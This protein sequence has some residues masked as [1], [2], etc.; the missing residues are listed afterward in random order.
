M[1]RPLAAEAAD[2]ENREFQMEEMSM[3]RG[4]I[5]I[6]VMLFVSTA[7]LS[8][9]TRA[10]VINEAAT[11]ECVAYAD[12]NIRDRDSAY[13][14]LL[15]R[16]ILEAV[17]ED[18]H[19]V[20]G[21]DCGSAIVLPP[22]VSGVAA[23]KAIASGSRDKSE[24]CAVMAGSDAGAD[25]ILAD[26]QS[27]VRYG[28]E[29]GVTALSIG[30]TNCNVGTE[31]VDCQYRTNKHPVEGLGLY[32]LNGD[33]FE[34]IG[35]S[36]V[37]H[38]FYALSESFCGPC[39]DVTNG[40]QLGVGCSDSNSAS[41]HACQTNLSPRSTINA[42]TG[43]F[44]HPW[45][46]WDDPPP[47]SIIERRLQVRTDDL[48]PVRNAG[49]RYFIEAHLI[50]PDDAA[51][52]TADNNASY[53]E[54][55]LVEEPPGIYNLAV[56]GDW[57]TQREQPAV[58]AWQDCDSSV[59]ETDIRVP[60]EGLFILAAKAAET[61]TGTW[62]YGYALQN[63][64][65]D[66]SGQSF[67]LSIPQD[68]I[69][70]NI[71]FAD[72]DYHSGEIYDDADWLYTIEDDALTWSTD[73]FTTNEDANALRWGTMYTFSF[74][75]TSPPV[76]TTATLGLFKPGVPDA[77]FVD[78]I[79]PTLAMV[80]CN[81]N[82]NDDRCDV[83]CGHPACDEPC[84]GSI[85]CDANGVP[86]ECEQDCNA[87]GIAD[88]CDLDGCLPGELWCADC[89]GNSVPDECDPDCD[90]DGI[91]DD[92]DV[93]DDA[94]GD[95]VPDCFDL[96]SC[97]PGLC[98]CPEVDRCC[99][100]FGLCLEGI[101]RDVCLES[102]GTPD[103]VEWPCEDGCITAEFDC[104]NNGIAD[105]RDVRCGPGDGCEPPCGTSADCND[106]GIPDRCDLAEGTSEDCQPDGVPDEC[107]LVG[108]DCDG[109]EVPDRCQP[110]VDRDGYIDACDNCP[111]DYN[112]VQAD[113]DGN[114]SGDVCDAHLDILP[115][116]CPNRVGAD[117]VL[118]V[119][120]VGASAFHVRQID[121]GSMFLA[122][123]DGDGG[124]VAAM[125]PHDLYPPVM[126]DIASP[127]PACEC[128]P[129]AADG[130]T[131][132]ELYFYTRDVVRLLKLGTESAAS[133]V[134]LVLRGR[135]HDGSEF[136]A[137]DCLSSEHPSPGAI[138]RPRVG[139]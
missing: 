92:C 110:D 99:W 42:Y 114:G 3:S 126:R 25:V 6:T 84:G 89:N 12:G 130:Q 23:V 22:G 15:N 45:E 50:G 33:R 96:C 115:D 95:G 100:P 18:G 62:R 132:L 38:W 66:R 67:R 68:G 55:L 37:F 65:S 97:T 139:R 64:N 29:G 59:V 107:Q 27:V 120:V 85:D 40:S 128:L 136:E 78:T 54:V 72:V 39:N 57:R 105:I 134:P 81:G 119:V 17:S 103:C 76:A 122:R 123:M 106:N 113:R 74:E 21:V 138:K 117:K 77:V 10:R 28:D 125:G 70:T 4:I 7:V 41:L 83:D 121:V 51:A 93:M 13:A 71:A 118:R 90:G 112:P 69:I 14:C 48:D 111:N 31:R 108:N 47:T 11:I 75:T 19:G 88:Q 98:V 135:L 137:V 5:S 30:T 109:N 24:S 82:G 73:T 60:G 46:G 80:D 86:D 34:Q 91:P 127:T 44:A 52:G 2:E 124:V 87:N 36:W 129:A 116:Q 53:R 16:K 43:Y 102:A 1:R 131:D 20:S 104:N 79:G 8:V 101:P 32:R 133:A 61:P 58:R 35:A 9:E 49:A 26:L 94:D 63:V 56:V